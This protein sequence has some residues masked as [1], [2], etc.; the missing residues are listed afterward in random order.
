[1]NHKSGSHKKLLQQLFIFNPMFTLDEVHILNCFVL[2]IITFPLIYQLVTVTPSIM[3]FDKHPGTAF[4]QTAW[5]IL[6]DSM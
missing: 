1:M 4:L 3:I 2:L 6:G 5:R